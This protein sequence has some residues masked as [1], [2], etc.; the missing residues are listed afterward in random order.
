VI[1]TNIT[2]ISSNGDAADSAKLLR[3]DVTEKR[4]RGIGPLAWCTVAAVFGGFDEIGT[5]DY[6]AQRS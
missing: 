3:A 6:A 2:H 5:Y 4:R 1:A